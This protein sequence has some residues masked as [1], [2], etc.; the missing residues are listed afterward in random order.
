MNQSTYLYSIDKDVLSIVD[1]DEDGSIS[2]TNNI[3]NVL[4]EIREKEKIN[5]DRY[6][7]V[8]RDC[9]CFWDGLTTQNNKFYEFFII[10]QRSHKVAI[11]Y[12]KNNKVYCSF[13][14]QSKF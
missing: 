4:E 7:I 9:Q 10:Q 3:E 11:D 2:L 1:L 13:L 8:Y 5:L 12:L 6:V 14:N